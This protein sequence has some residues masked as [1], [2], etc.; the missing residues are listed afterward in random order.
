[1]DLD[2]ARQLLQDFEL[3]LGIAQQGIATIR[4]FTEGP[5]FAPEASL[6][7]TVEDL[8][9]SPP[10]PF[11]APPD[12][13]NEQLP[14]DHSEQLPADPDEQFPD[15]WAPPTPP[16]S[17]DKK[18]AGCGG[19]RG[20]PEGPLL[21]LYGHP[22]LPMD[23][24]KLPHRPGLIP[25]LRLIPKPRNLGLRGRLISSVRLRSI[26]RPS[27]HGLS[28]PRD[29]PAQSKI[30]RLNGPCISELA[31][32][33]ALCVCEPSWSTD[34]KTLSSRGAV[35]RHHSLPNEDSDG[36]VVKS[37][38]DAF[39]TYLQS[40][41][42]DSFCGFCLSLLLPVRCRCCDLLLCICI[43][44]FLLTAVFISASEASRD[45]CVCV[46]RGARAC[47]AHYA[48][49][50]HMLR[51]VV[52]E[53]CTL[54][55]GGDLAAWACY[56]PTGWRAGLNDLP[57]SLCCADMAVHYAHQASLPIFA[58]DFQ[59]W[60]ACSAARPIAWD[61]SERPGQIARWPGFPLDMI[62][63]QKGSLLPPFG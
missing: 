51:W 8:T 57:V 40:L 23:N 16:S 12:D 5:D 54:A 43:Q 44:A 45:K 25:L 46:F 59:V 21:T 49:W 52:M 63:P 31:P 37:G 6:N 20:A 62:N 11:L 33:G 61:K 14:E 36:L 48:V 58:S 35:D 1:M 7:L 38:R 3:I 22:N 24:A 50:P 30:A 15:H 47:P 18:R 4:E 55:A 27:M 28:S 29:F 32:P 13:L 34:A 53:D 41:F 39:W 2:T 9:N 19:P 56:V 42:P 10:T 60:R 26:P 17:P